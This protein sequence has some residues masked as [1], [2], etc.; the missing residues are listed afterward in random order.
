[1]RYIF[2]ILLSC[3]G[4][5]AKLVNAKLPSIILTIGTG[6]NS[7]NYFKVG[8]TFCDIINEKSNDIKCIVRTTNGSLENINLTLSDSTSIGI[9][10]AD[11]L[12]NSSKKSDLKFIAKLYLEPVFI[13]ASKVSDAKEFNDI[14]LQNNINIGAKGAGENDTAKL[15]IKAKGWQKEGF[16]EYGRYEILSLLCK[17]SVDIAF[18][19]GVNPND[20]VFDIIKKC[21]STLVSMEEDFISSFTQKYPEFTAFTIMAGTY[22]NQANPVKTV[23]TESILFASKETSADL[24]TEILKIIFEDTQVLQNSNTSFGGRSLKSF[25]Q[26]NTKLETHKGS[27]NFLKEVE[28]GKITLK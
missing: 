21:G 23:A 27:E 15:L 18:L 10:Q 3:F 19:T 20:F 4:L 17:N 1:M 13:L 6:A 28:Q 11:T 24:I 26:N 8:N 12:I 16:T 5:C 14:L 9:A 25:F 22:N 7:G 2:L